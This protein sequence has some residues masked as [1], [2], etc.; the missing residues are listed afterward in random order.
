MPSVRYK[1]FGSDVSSL[2]KA[3]IHASDISVIIKVDYRKKGL[4]YYT[5]YNAEFAGKYTIQ[6]PE[7][8]NIYLSFIFPYPTNQ[9]EGV[10]QNVKLLVNGEEDIEDTEYQ[11]N[12]TLWTGVLGPTE[13]L[14]ITVQYD[15]RGLNLCRL[16][17]IS[18]LVQMCLV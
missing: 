15:G 3:E 7:N 16:C 17:V 4:V 10:L 5:G 11:P 9:G 12:L 1:R 8:E 2:S 6:N 14:E 13:S 18:V